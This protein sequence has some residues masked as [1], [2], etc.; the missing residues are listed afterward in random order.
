M[1][2]AKEQQK[3]ND[4]LDLVSEQNQKNGNEITK[5]HSTVRDFQKSF[6]E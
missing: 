3:S 2:L 1:A 4:E 5:F 6:Q